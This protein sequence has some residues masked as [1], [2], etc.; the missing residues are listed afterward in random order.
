MHLITLLF[1]KHLYIVLQINITKGHTM[2]TLQKHIL[3]KLIMNYCFGDHHIMA[4]TIKH[5]LPKHLHGEVK[6][7]LK[8]LVKQGLILQL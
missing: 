2:N 5:G 1:C 7:E 8:T 6:T 4:D 3:E